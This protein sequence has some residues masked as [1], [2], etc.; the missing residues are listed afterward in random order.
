MARLAVESRY[1]PLYE[2]EAGRHRLT[3]IPRQPVSVRVWLERQ[4][5]FRHL[6]EDAA[7]LQAWADEN[8]LRLSIRASS[9]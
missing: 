1:W 6:L 7:A 2:V 4:G 3:H 8:W 9:G 5:R